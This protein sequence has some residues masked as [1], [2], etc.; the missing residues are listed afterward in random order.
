MA[1]V[2]KRKTFLSHTVRNILHGIAAGLTREDPS[3]MDLK[4]IIVCDICLS[5]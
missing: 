4:F 3:G 1:F 2:L 5:Y